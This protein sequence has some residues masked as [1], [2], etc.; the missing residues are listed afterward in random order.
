MNRLTNNATPTPQPQPNPQPDPQTPPTPQEPQKDGYNWYF[1]ALDV[2]GESG[3]TVNFLV[4]S[5]NGEPKSQ[6]MTNINKNAKKLVYEW[7]VNNAQA[8]QTSNRTGYPAQNIDNGKLGIYVYSNAQKVNVHA[9][10]SA[11]NLTG[12][13][14]GATMNRLTDNSTP[15]PQPPSPQPQ[16][17]PPTPQPQPNPPS[18][19]PQP[20][21]PTPQ[22]LPNP[23]T[24]QP[25]PNPPSPQ[26][27]P[28]PPT[29]QEPEED[30]PS[31]VDPDDIAA[32][33][34]IDIKLTKD[35]RYLNIRLG[36]RPSEKGSVD[37]FNIYRSEVRDSGYKCIAQNHH[38][39]TY[40]DTTA[41]IAKSGHTYY[42][43]ATAVLEGV[44]G[45]WGNMKGIFIRPPCAYAIN[46]QCRIKGT[47]LPSKPKDSLEIPENNRDFE[48][49]YKKGNGKWS[50][51]DER[52]FNNKFKPLFRYEINC[53]TG[54]VSW[55]P[56][57]DI[58]N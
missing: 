12:E 33:L 36:L 43:R 3:D 30:P 11:G 49:R 40:Q 38:G 37:T 47:I 2:S 52:T 54:I 45:K 29:P 42:Y 18:P 27:Q 53:K 9:W 5:G 13:W 57:L 22:P 20:N 58:L 6:D 35:E 41:N 4:S 50:K 15:T 17:N 28:N 16:P 55:E 34:V 48:I 25:Q 46:G 32:P 44:E 10:G 7:D 56:K 39:L 14:P 26:P 19:Q 23:P 8:L 1:Y 31:E 21:P 51:W 24:P